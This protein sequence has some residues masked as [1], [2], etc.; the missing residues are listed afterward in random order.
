MAERKVFRVEPIS[1]TEGKEQYTIQCQ[2]CKKVFDVAEPE[3]VCFDCGSLLQVDKAK[4]FPH[5]NPFPPGV[6]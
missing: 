6:R 5:F 3:T 1:K 4:Y 2:C